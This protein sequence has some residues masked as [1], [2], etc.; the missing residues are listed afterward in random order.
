[1]SASTNLP[2]LPAPLERT[3]AAATVAAG[4]ARPTW[5]PGHVADP[6]ASG[7]ADG[8]VRRPLRHTGHRLVVAS[9][10][11]TAIV[12]AVQMTDRTTGA[13]TAGDGSLRFGALVVAA[14]YLVAQCV[15]AAWTRRQRLAIDS[16]RPSTVSRRTWSGSWATAWSLTFVVGALVV[17]GLAAVG[18]HAS[19]TAVVGVAVV[20]VRVEML[21]VLGAD[22]G[23]VV[24]GARRWSEVSGLVTAVADGLVVAVLAAV[25]V[26]DGPDRLALPAT[27]GAASLALLGVALFHLAF[28]K[29]VDGWTVEWWEQRHGPV[30]IADVHVDALPLDAPTAA[31]RGDGEGDAGELTPVWALRY[32]VLVAFWFAGATTVGAG[33]TMAWRRDA[34]FVVSDRVGSLARVEGSIG[35]VVV[36]LLL[37]QL[38][39]AAWTVTQLRN[40]RRRGL[41]VADPTA[42]ALGF[43]V[44][45][46]ILLTA[47]WVAPRWQL[48]VVT[49]ALLVNLAAWANSFDVLVRT[50]QQ[51]GRSANVVATW[52][53]L[54]STH[55]VLVLV[56]VPLATVVGESRTSATLVALAVVDGVVLL[57]AGIA[58]WR[59]TWGLDR[60]TARRLGGGRLTGP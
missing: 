9:A 44:A 13:S 28:M 36:S 1:M 27:A 33:A 12:V 26:G 21:R 16:M 6:S 38:A 43:L 35:A 7:H 14:G 34:S 5:D 19:L 58:G 41:D 55:W 47:S 23:R 4:T 10:A 32:A 11:A 57:A 49:L 53:R 59:V 56:V 40:A 48:A 22:M 37:L 39:Q 24:L 60:A 25:L 50:M 3:A 18:A 52:S 8:S 30:D 54:V 17:I 2:S 51:L 20:A 45:P 15:F 31:G 46:S 42:I 29:R